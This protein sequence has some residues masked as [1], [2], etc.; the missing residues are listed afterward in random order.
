M[1]LFSTNGLILC[2]ALLIS[3]IASAAAHNNV[4]H[5]NKHSMQSLSQNISY[6]AHGTTDARTAKMF[7][8]LLK[9][10]KALQVTA[11][12]RNSAPKKDVD[13]AVNYTIKGKTS[14]KNVKKLIQ[15]FKNSR[16]V[17]VRARA[18]VRSNSAIRGQRFSFNQPGT[19]TI[20]RFNHSSNRYNRQLAKR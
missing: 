15:L 14:V 10:S 6:T 3:G 20:N 13:V 2:S 4:L 9:N 18:N 16:Y 1:N 5:K 7:R 8:Q 19:W 17:Q 12:V 11:S